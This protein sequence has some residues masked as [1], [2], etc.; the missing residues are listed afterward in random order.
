MMLAREKAKM[1][2]ALAGLLTVLVA[3]LGLASPAGAGLGVATFTVSVSKSGSGQGTV[4][5]TPDGIDCGSL[6]EGE[7]PL[8]SGGPVTLTATSARGS[9]FKGWDGTIKGT[10]KRL[11]VQPPSDGLPVEVEAVFDEAARP[12]ARLWGRAVRRGPV[13]RAVSLGVG[14]GEPVSCRLRV[15]AVVAIWASRKGYASYQA[16]ARVHRSPEV[17]KSYWNVAVGLGRLSRRMNAALKKYPE[18]PGTIRIEVED[19]DTGLGMAI[20]IE[21]IHW[22]HGTKGTK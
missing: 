8:F 11:S 5:S 18:R 19:L 1:G 3:M 22:T 2:M 10:S 9:R 4:A 16:L 17:D 14:C 7:F 6:C 20:K 12:V 21:H 13:P 15:S